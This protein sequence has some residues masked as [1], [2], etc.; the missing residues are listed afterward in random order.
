MSNM[1]AWQ[2]LWKMSKCND[3]MYLIREWSRIMNGT[4]SPT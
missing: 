2:V 4:E 1:R 3:A